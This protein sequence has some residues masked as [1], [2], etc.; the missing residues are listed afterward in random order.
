MKSIQKKGISQI[1]IEIVIITVFIVIIV[2][3]IIVGKL[4]RSFDDFKQYGNESINLWNKIMGVE[5]K[6]AIEQDKAVFMG[7]Y[8]SFIDAYNNCL[9]S[10]K[11]SCFCQIPNI[12]KLVSERFY[13]SFEQLPEES[14]VTKPVTSGEDDQEVYID[15]P[16]VL[17]G[18]FCIALDASDIPPGY[19]FIIQNPPAGKL[20]FFPGKSNPL[21]VLGAKDDPSGVHVSYPYYRYYDYPQ[22]LWYGPI[23]TQ[24]TQADY[25]F[26]KLPSS[27]SNKN[28][29]CFYNYILRIRSTTQDGKTVDYNR[30][31]FTD[32]KSSTKSH[33]IKPN[34]LC[35]ATKS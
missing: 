9:K 6:K 7:I 19:R 22:N 24:D 5:E 35:S 10:T 11:T 23:E 21:G 1:I 14:F 28:I 8:E 26:Y 15:D 17:S 29:I 34:E 2:L 33:V 12:N 27:E 3:A 25:F 18:K 30:K 4:P 31:V 16:I 32:P 20:Y 13:I